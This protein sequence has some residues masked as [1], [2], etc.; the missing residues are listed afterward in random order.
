MR[1]AR[2]GHALLATLALPVLVPALGVSPAAADRLTVGAS[3]GETRGDQ[4]AVARGPGAFVRLRAGARSLIELD[5]ARSAPESEAHTSTRLGASLVLELSARGRGLT[6]YLVAGGGV[7]RTEHAFWIGDHRHLE[8]GAGL[9]L[10][11]GERAWLGVDA[12][13]GQRDLVDERLPHDPVILI[14]IPPALP[15]HH[16]YTSVRLTLSFAL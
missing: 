16:T 2:G 3:L 7:T 4:L 8:V 15:A 1:S 13:A 10:A 11:L 12:R 5:V 9:D 14:Y 6:P